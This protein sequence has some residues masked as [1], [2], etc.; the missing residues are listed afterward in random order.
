MEKQAITVTTKLFE[1][2]MLKLLVERL[3]HLRNDGSFSHEKAGMDWLCIDTS[4]MEAYINGAMN[5]F[6]KNDLISMPFTSSFLFTCIKRKGGMY[7]LT[8]VSS[9]S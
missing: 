1:P 5:L 4:T 2:T 6:D 3:A 9:L 7:D 8:W